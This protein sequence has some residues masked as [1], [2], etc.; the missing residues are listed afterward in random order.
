VFEI[1]KLFVSSVV[2]CTALVCTPVAVA[3]P[4]ETM[5]ERAL[6]NHPKLQA[7]VSTARSVEFEIEQAKAATRWRVGVVSDVGRGLNFN[8]GSN[9]TNATDMAVRGN[10]LIYDGERADNEIERQ[11]KR[12]SASGNR[13]AQTREQLASQLVDL[14]L[15]V[16]K[17]REVASVLAE[18]VASTTDLFEKV[19]AIVFLDRGR[20]SE[21]TQVAVRLQQ[22]KASQAARRNAAL[23]A[24]ALLDDLAGF[25]VQV[26]TISTTPKQSPSWPLV[27]PQALRMV[28][29]HPLVK[30]SQDEADAALRAAKISAAW[31]RPRVEIQTGLIS[32]YDSSGNRRYL[33]GVDIR[34]AVNWQPYD[35]GAGA[36]GAAAASQLAGAAEQQVNAVKKDI[37]ADV[38]KIWTQIQSRED[39][40]QFQKDLAV[41]AQ[42]VR[43]AYWEQFKIGRR[44]I[45]ELLNADNET[46]QARVVARQ[47]FLEGIQSQYRLLGALARLGQ[48]FNLSNIGVNPLGSKSP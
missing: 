21:L 41:K 13:I 43:E 24:Q 25:V 28:D 39:Q 42:L 19:E 2:V 46:F 26:Q 40:F 6:S 38:A 23:E 32:P 14:Y 35:G 3:Q 31:N 20:N 4:I 12:F 22:A 10:K 29:E 17:Q 7:A 47:E 16:L 44:A 11:T 15:E 27:L 5:L 1:H 45:L 33:S 36:A 34:L 9:G 30:V 18:Q 48:Q 37:S 8:T